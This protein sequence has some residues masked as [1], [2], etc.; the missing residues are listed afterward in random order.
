MQISIEH[1]IEKIEEEFNEVKP[2]TLKPDTVFKDA[3]QWNS[4]NALLI[5]AI[6]TAE[7]DVVV[8]PDELKDCN[9]IQ[10]LFNIILSKK[11]G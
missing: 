11:A 3:F 8:S 5:M 10:S 1:F 2:G 9:T 4:M 7:Y 6:V